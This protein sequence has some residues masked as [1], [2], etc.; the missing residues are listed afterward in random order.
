MRTQRAQA[1]TLVAL[2][3]LMAGQTSAWAHATD[4]THV[5]APFLSGM[6]HLFG[7]GFHAWAPAMFGAIGSWFAIWSRRD[8]V[9]HLFFIA[10]TLSYALSHGILWSGEGWEFALGL[11][12]A[13]LLA[14]GIGAL[15]TLF[16]MRK[17]ARER[18][19]ARSRRRP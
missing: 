3:L 7:L 9:S 1:T 13:A 16:G 4:A 15:A 6:A 10:L 11:I 17:P 18:S 2:T 5:E 14:Y 12:L 19:R 8:T